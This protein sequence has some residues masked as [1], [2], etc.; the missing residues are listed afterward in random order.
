MGAAQV[1]ALW[2]EFDI[3]VHKVKGYMAAGGMQLIILWY[4][5]LEVK[6]NENSKA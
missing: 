2:Q 4:E 6:R 3:W 5:W 1:K